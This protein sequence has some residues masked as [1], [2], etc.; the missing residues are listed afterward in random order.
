MNFY[1]TSEL[2]SNLN[3]TRVAIN[4]LPHLNDELMITPGGRFN[5]LFQQVHEN[6]IVFT[7]K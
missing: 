4:R 1:V 5:Q 2:T 3:T 7:V 6:Y